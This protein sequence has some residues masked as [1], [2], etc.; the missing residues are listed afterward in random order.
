MKQ[1]KGK[2]N[3]MLGRVLELLPN[4]TF[5]VQLE[6]SQELLAHLSGKMRLNFIRILP[7]DRVLVEVSPDGHRG[8]IVYRYK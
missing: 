7:G 3:Q 2:A 4:A 8:R 5:R 6:N 1:E